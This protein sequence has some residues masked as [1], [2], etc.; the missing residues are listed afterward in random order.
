MPPM[1]GPSK[2]KTKWAWFGKQKGASGHVRMIGWVRVGSPKWNS[3]IH[4]VNTPGRTGQGP[5]RPALRPSRY[6]SAANRPVGSPGVLKRIAPPKKGPTNE[7]AGRN[8]KGAPSQTKGPVRNPIGNQPGAPGAKKGGVKKAKTTNARNQR[9]VGNAI[10]KANVQ[11]TVNVNAGAKAA[12][13]AQFGAAISDNRLQQA[14]QGRTGA[15]DLA[16]ITNWYAALAKQN[17][18]GAQ[19]N[20]AQTAAAGQHVQNIASSLIDQI[21]GSAN[22]DSGT[23][24]NHGIDALAALL[25]T[26]QTQANFEQNRAEADTAAQAGQMSAQ[27]ALN[28]QAMTGLQQALRDLQIQRGAAVTLAKQQ[29]Q[30]QNNA[31]RQGNFGNRISALDA[32]IGAAQAAGNMQIQGLQIA[33]GRQ[34]LKQQKTAAKGGNPN[35]VPWD[36]LPTSGKLSAINAMIGGDPSKTPYN[37]AVARGKA[38]GFAPQRFQALLHTYYIK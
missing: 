10:G 12:G 5:H 8:A 22:Q 37:I 21:G 36:K 25:G 7:V 3:L 23:I 33:Q 24:A 29:L 11:K 14:E 1:N 28:S 31:A 13:A 9:V 34:Q 32:R 19:M 2:G 35:F 18:A 4:P 16:D 17:A 20:Q 38:M 30:Q 15:Q 6:V 27:Q 26:G